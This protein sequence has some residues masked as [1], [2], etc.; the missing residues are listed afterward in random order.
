MKTET[1]EAFKP[2]I[3]HLKCNAAKAIALIIQAFTT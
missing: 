2:N 1:N 3:T